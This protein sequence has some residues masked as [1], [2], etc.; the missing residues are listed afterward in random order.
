MGGEEAIGAAWEAVSVVVVVH[1]ED[2][3]GKFKE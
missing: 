3:R 2:G 1:L